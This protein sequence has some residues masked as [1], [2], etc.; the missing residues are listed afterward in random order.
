MAT[1][2][3]IE[4][5]T[6]KKAP[7]F[8]VLNPS[9]AIHEV[10]KEQAAQLFRKQGYRKPTNAQVKQYLGQRVQTHDNPIGEPWSPDP[11]EGVD[12]DSLSTEVTNDEK[13]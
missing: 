11:G 6:P 12:V 9:G 2:K 7:R 3:K 10:T 4:A 8:F 13:Q 1:T 5:D